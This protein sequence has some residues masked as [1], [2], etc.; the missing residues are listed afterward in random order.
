MSKTPERI[1][2]SNVRNVA[3]S[4]STKQKMK[5]DISN[6]FQCDICLKKFK[7][8]SGLSSHMKTHNVQ[9]PD[10][11]DEKV[12]VQ[13]E[14]PTAWVRKY[15]RNGRTTNEDMIQIL[16]KQKRIAFIINQDPN[17]KDKTYLCG[18]NEQ[19]F[20]YPTE[21]YIELPESIVTLIKQQYKA[22]QAALKTNLVSRSDD[23]KSALT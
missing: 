22:T 13:T 15:A 3:G 5:E 14:D 11:P 16:S 23:V 6:P 8:K 20:E 17:T 2:A 10:S 1:T 18:I 19:D 4:A 7:N 9:R 12:P 21:D